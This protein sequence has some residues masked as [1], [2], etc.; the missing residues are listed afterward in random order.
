MSATHAIDDKSSPQSSLP[1]SICL[2]FDFG[3]Y[4]SP[5][6]NLT[7]ASFSSCRILEAVGNPAFS[8]SVGIQ[9]G[10]ASDFLWFY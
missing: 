3:L 2:G 4:I 8:E 6:S 1:N 5:V 7:A 9:Q 10:S